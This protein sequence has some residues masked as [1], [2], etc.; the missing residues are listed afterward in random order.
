MTGWFILIGIIVVCIAALHFLRNRGG[1]VEGFG[2]F[3]DTQKEFANKQATYFHEQA[4]KAILINPGVRLVGLN[5][6]LKQPD[7]Y[8]PNSPDRD[9]TTYLMEDPENAFTEQDR[10]FCAEARHP[11]DLP[12]RV[13]RATVGCGWYYNPDPSVPSV[14]ALGTR[15]GGP[16]FNDKLPAGGQWF[17]NRAQAAEA[18]DIKMCKRIRTCELLDV[19]GVAGQ[20]GFCAQRGYSVPINSDGSQKYPDSREGSC[21]GP[22]S[23]Q[24]SECDVPDAVITEDGTDCRNFGRPSP[25]NNLRLYTKAECDTLGG[26]LTG[27]GECL[28]PEGSSFSFE[29]RALNYPS[30]ARRSATAQS[31]CAPNSSGILSRDCLKLLANGMGMGDTGSIVRQIM[32]GASTEMDAQAMDVLRGVGLTIPSSVLGDGNIS[33]SAAGTIYYRV[34]SL[35]RDGPNEQVKNAAKYLAIGSSEFNPCPTTDD[36]RG[37]FNSSC[38]QK[39]F[40]KSGCQAG[41]AKYP[42]ER[43]AVS[44]LATMSWGQIKASFSDLFGRMQSSNPDVQNEAIRDCLG[45]GSEYYRPT[46]L[47]CPPNRAACLEERIATSL[48]AL[49]RFCAFTASTPITLN[50]SNPDAFKPYVNTEDESIYLTRKS[51]FGYAASAFYMNRVY[52][53]SFATSFRIR[54]SETIAD[55]VTFILQNSGANA[56]GSAGWALGAHGIQPYAGIR[57]DTFSNPAI[58][59]IGYIDNMNSPIYQRAESGDI[60]SMMGFKWVWDP[61]VMDVTIVYSGNTLACTVVN[62]SQPWRKY[63]FTRD[64][65][66]SAVLGSSG[67]WAGFTAST[68][69]G[70]QTTQVMWWK[71]YGSHAT[72]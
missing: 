41:G 7:L 68:G 67:A 46:P 71:F 12:A 69:G 20:C 10:K 61:W 72:A 62:A 66:L 44:E 5:D 11:R 8:L 19:D 58:L 43:S 25:D 9:Y 21:G 33:P 37:P 30:Y 35:M 3:K 36:A 59:S 60:T 18:E 56:L 63:T 65:D 70:T 57:I 26:T 39:E 53:K 16:I 49:F 42:S 32:G 38:L 17:W 48:P 52:V 6:A 24:P 29:C 54:L 22:V 13:K 55:G 14:G 64:V 47:P 2:E 45:A 51:I 34:Y 4:D 1:E 23:K 40:R 50:G 31:V 27:A 28:K 15:A